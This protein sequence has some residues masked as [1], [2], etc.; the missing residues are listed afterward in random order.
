MHCSHTYN[1]RSLFDVRIARRTDT[2]RPSSDFDFRP[3]FYCT[4]PG[5]LVIYREAGKEWSGCSVVHES[6]DNC[7]VDSAKYVSATLPSSRD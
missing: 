6:T 3:A 4:V 5:A 2:I 7:G 1:A